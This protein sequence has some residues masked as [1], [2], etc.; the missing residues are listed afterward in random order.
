MLFRF[1]LVLFHKFRCPSGLPRHGTEDVQWVRLMPNSAMHLEESWL[2]VANRPCVIGRHNKLQV[3][4]AVLPLHVLLVK[5]SHD[6]P[7]PRSNFP[8][9]L[10]S[11]LPVNLAYDR[12]YAKSS[13]RSKAKGSL[14][15]QPIG[16]TPRPPVSRSPSAELNPTRHCIT[17]H[18]R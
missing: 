7:P 3:V 1:V 15:A 4:W 11:C 5:P 16:M 2:E 10:L 18:G 14:P 12:T 9:D 8:G 6:R 17:H 13:P